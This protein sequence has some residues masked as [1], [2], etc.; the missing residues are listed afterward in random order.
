ME[1]H[2]LLID[3]DYCSMEDLTAEERML[4][5][6]AC[7]ATHNAYARYSHF[8]VGAALLL[9]EIGRAHV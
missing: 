5:E 8:C 2:K 6:R 9:N 4:V 7:D 3:Y 1:H